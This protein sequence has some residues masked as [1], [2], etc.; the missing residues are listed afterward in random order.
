MPQA[1]RAELDLAWRRYKRDLRNRCFVYHPWIESDLPSWLDALAVEI[2]HDYAPRPSQLVAVPKAGNLVRPAAILEPED[3]VV[4]NFAVGR[5][6]PGIAQHIAWSQGAID[7][8]YPL[9]KS[10][11]AVDWTQPGFL[12]WQNFG[13]VS[14]QRLTDDVDYVVFTD[15]TGFYENID[16]QRLAS[17]LSAI[18]TD[19]GVVDL[20]QRCLRNWALPRSEGIPQGYSASDILAKL[21]LDSVDRN[22]KAAGVDHV[23]YVDDTRMFCA[24]KLQARQAIRRLTAL[25]YP[26][27]LNLQSAKTQILTRTR[28]KRRIDGATDAI[29]G[30]NRKL[31]RELSEA[32]GGYFKP[33]EV[34]R[35]LEGHTGPTPEVLERA[36]S[37]HFEDV[38]ES[39]FDSTLFH[40]LLARLAKVHSRV[41]IAYSL[42]LLKTRPEETAAILKYFSQVGLEEGERDELVAYVSSEEA[43]FDY[44]IYEI[45]RWFYDG[46]QNHPSLLDLCRQ[47]ADD[48]NRD[49]AV[50]SYAFAYIGQF[51]PTTAL[52]DIEE[53]YTNATTELERADRVAAL[54]RMERGRR[55][56]FYA[57]V[58]AHGK[59]VSRAIAVAR[60]AG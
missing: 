27:G 3:A 14:T 30:L 60:T 1:T 6:L 20:L 5:A 9:P 41:A 52:P 22:L 33:E 25:L 24:T 16:I 55:N 49:A 2:E 11:D 53:S 50:R 58:S 34:L 43:I 42:K 32:D 59:L 57:R 21:Y 29:R 19:R 18:G 45:V 28:A 31:A 47:W 38:S 48:R 39:K 4:Y 37:E 51:S 54:T 46:D 44:Q 23:R 40:F 7:I 15:I 10:P 35:A 13:Q 36:F 56:A 12:V 8:P 17:D 26:K